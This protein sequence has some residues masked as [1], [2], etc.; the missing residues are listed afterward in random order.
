MAETFDAWA[1]VEIMGHDRIAGRLT[2]QTIA[3]CGFVRVDVPPLAGEK[4]YTK[5]FG[6]SAI[7]SITCVTEDMALAAA[8]S[9]YRKAPIT[10]YEIA[11]L[12]QKRLFNDRRTDVEADDGNDETPW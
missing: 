9:Y 10:A 11:A 4:G 1:I 8:A 3:G 7:F 6:P 2:E 12:Q 5:L